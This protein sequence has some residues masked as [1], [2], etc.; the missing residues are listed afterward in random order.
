[1]DRWGP[2]PTILFVCC[3]CSVLCVLC[4][5]LCLVCNLFCFVCDLFSYLCK[6]FSRVCDTFLR[7]YDAIPLL[8]DVFWCFFHVTLCHKFVF[9]GLISQGC[10]WRHHCSC[11]RLILTDWLLQGTRL[12]S[13]NP[14]GMFPLGMKHGA[15]LFELQAHR[16]RKLS[17]SWQSDTAKPLG[18]GCYE[19]FLLYNLLLSVSACV[20]VCVYL[21]K[22]T[23]VCW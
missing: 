10:C 8:C 22:R 7:V 23:D 4:F 17:V 1:M 18:V 15:T 2:L 11:L 12:G 6:T 19:N 13:K 21:Q 3:I 16:I 14:K 5:V 9:L 20:C